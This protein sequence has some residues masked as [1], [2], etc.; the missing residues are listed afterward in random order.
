MPFQILDRK[1]K[2]KGKGKGK[3]SPVLAMN[4][5]WGVEIYVHEFLTSALDGGEW[6]ASHPAALPS[7]KEHLLPTG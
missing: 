4:M 3:T 6:S 2:G 1:G 7:G 5:Y